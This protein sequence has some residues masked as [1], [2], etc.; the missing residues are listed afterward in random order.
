M[1]H[2]RRGVTKNRQYFIMKD[3]KKC[4]GARWRSWLHC[5]TSRKVAGSIPY[6]VIGIFH[7]INP[8][9]RTMALRST[10]PV[11]EMCARS[12]SWGVKR[13]VRRVD[14]LTTI[15]CRSSRKSGSLNLL[16]FCTFSRGVLLC[17]IQIHATVDTTPFFVRTKY[18]V[19][20]PNTYSNSAAHKFGATVVIIG[21]CVKHVESCLWMP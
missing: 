6:G 13:T 19:D 21:A 16:E 5:A 4:W 17:L 10:L 14:N 15:L 2:T 1:A 12:I 11:T 7:W 8:S 20:S 18:I 9:S 3:Q